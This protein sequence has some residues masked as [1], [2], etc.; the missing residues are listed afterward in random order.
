MPGC[1]PPRREETGNGFMAPPRR[2][3]ERR[4]RT[5]PSSTTAASVVRSLAACARAWASNSSRMSTVAFTIIIVPRISP[6]PTPWRRAFLRTGGYKRHGGTTGRLSPRRVPRHDPAHGPAPPRV[7]HDIPDPEPVRL[8]S[9]PA[10]R[11][12]TAAWRCRRAPVRFR[13]VGYRVI[14]CTRRRRSRSCFGAPYLAVAFPRWADPSPSRLGCR[15]CRRFA[16]LAAS[17]LP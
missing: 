2:G 4:R 3:V 15:R 7:D 9:I 1:K 6:R 16:I 17:S 5:S 12:W 10:D 11:G 13:F 8:G 14:C